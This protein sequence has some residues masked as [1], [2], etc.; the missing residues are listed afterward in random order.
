MQQLLCDGNVRVAREE[1][2]T[3]KYITHLISN[4]C[5][6]RGAFTRRAPKRAE[7]KG[8]GAK[9]FHSTSTCCFSSVI[10]DLY[11]GFL[12]IPGSNTELTLLISPTQ[13]SHTGEMKNCSQAVTGVSLTL[14]V[15]VHRQSVYDKLN[16]IMVVLPFF[17]FFASMLTYPFVLVSNLMAVNNCG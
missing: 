10:C 16:L 4:W 2:C 6:C 15:V 13:M 12:L 1:N 8:A 17:Q 7:G 11:R 5:L 9:V 3:S 14:A